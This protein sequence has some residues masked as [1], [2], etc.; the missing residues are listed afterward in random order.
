VSQ[1]KLNAYFSS[2]GA[3][4]PAHIVLLDFSNL[5]IFGE[6]TNHE[7]RLGVLT[8]IANFFL[9]CCRIINLTSFIFEITVEIGYK[10]VEGIEEMVS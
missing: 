1:L 8:Y 2:V 7:I 10:V 5:I 3:T 4:C 6:D 9:G